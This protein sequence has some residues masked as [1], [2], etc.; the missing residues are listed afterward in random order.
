MHRDDAAGAGHSTRA[1]DIRF[2]APQA[3]PR[4]WP[5]RG[6]AAHYW[7]PTQPIRS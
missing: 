1:P 4:I 6:A 2:R 7:S 5:R 3:M